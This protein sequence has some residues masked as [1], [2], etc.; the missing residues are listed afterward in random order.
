MEQDIQQ[1]SMAVMAMRS[2]SSKDISTADNCS[3]MRHC[4]SN[5]QASI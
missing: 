3:K 2:V 1:A 5:S 4:N